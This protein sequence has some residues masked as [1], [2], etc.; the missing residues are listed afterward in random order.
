MFKKTVIATAVAV[1][2]INAMAATMDTNFSTTAAKHSIEGIE[3]VV[4]ATGVL[5]SS[6]GVVRVAAEMYVGDL[7]KLDYSVGLAGAN[8]FPTS[9]KSFIPGTGASLWQTVAECSTTAICE[10]ETIAGQNGTKDAIGAAVWKVGDQFTATGSATVHT[11]TEVDGN[12]EITFTPAAAA[13]IA[14]DVALV[15]KQPDVM[16]L[17]RQTVTSSSVTYRVGGITAKGGSRV[18]A[19]IPLPAG[20][21]VKA[22]D[23][24]TTPAT[25]A[26]SATTAAGL[27]IDSVASPVAIGSAVAAYT[28]TIAKLD[29][30]VDVE[31]DRKALVGGTAESSADTLTMSYAQPTLAAGT[32]V[33]ELTGNLSLPANNAA[34]LD[35]AS[36]TAVHTINGDFVFMDNGAAA[37]VQTTGLS[38]DAGTTTLAMATTGA[39]FTVTDTALDPANI[40]TI[41][42]NVAAAVIPVQSFSGSTVLSY[43]N[44]AG[45]AKTKT[46]THASLGAFTLNGAAVTAYAVPMGDT[47]SRFLWVSNKGVADATLNATVIAEGTSYGPYAI[48]TASGKKATSVGGLIDTALSDAGV[49][50]PNNSRATITIDSPVKQA[51]ITV[52][53]AYKHIGDAD[54]LILETSDTLEDSLSLTGLTVTKK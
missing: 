46:I 9:F 53:A 21:L 54:R 23:L 15:M 36:E 18:G 7:V 34:A 28:Q 6:G 47:V 33:S 5:V 51:D 3:G 10:I 38:D 42:K 4:D 35:W 27:A 1:A 43:N 29:G 31:K 12:G 45:T 48:G 8:T 52:S 50:L 37:G 11:V 26:Y 41:T 17:G 40:I 2:S 16:D 20:V 30:V 49:T 24:V 44:S 32:S 13:K 19:A 22:A 14:A 39:K 25:V